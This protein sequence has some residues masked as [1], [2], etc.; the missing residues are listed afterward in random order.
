MILLSTIGADA[1]EL[2]GDIERYTG[3]GYSVYLHLN[4]LSNSKAMARAINRYVGVDGTL[5]RYVSPRLISEYGDK[6]TQ[7]YLYLTGQVQWC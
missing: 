5:G 4:E 1:D 2:A 6:P 7:T 3:Y